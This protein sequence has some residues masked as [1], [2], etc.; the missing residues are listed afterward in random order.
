MN[1]KKSVIAS[2]NW[3]LNATTAAVRKNFDGSVTAWSVDD[4]D[5]MKTQR[6]DEI[7]R[8]RGL[9]FF[10]LNSVVRRYVWSSAAWLSKLVY[11]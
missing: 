1:I 2:K 5:A 8:R 10:A 11:S 6:V 4:F 3:T 7:R 9:S